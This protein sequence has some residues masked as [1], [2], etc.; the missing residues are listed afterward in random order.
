V[1]RERLYAQ[2]VQISRTLNRIAGKSSDQRRAKEFILRAEQITHEIEAD[3]KAGRIPKEVRFDKMFHVRKATEEVRKRLHNAPESFTGRGEKVI[4]KG[5]QLIKQL[6]GTGPGE[7]AAGVYDI[8]QALKLGA[9]AARVYDIIVAC[10]KDE[11][12]DKPELHERLIRRIHA[13]L[14]ARMGRDTE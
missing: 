13:A 1:A 10:L 14:E 11:F 12:S 3:V 8:K 7:P 9:E 6:E 2:G 5:D 4:E